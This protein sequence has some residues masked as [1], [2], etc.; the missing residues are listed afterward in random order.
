[1]TFLMV[2]EFAR[3]PTLSAALFAV[4]IAATLSSTVGF[5]FSA[6]AAGILLQMMNDQVAVVEIMLISSIALQMYSVALLRRDI[7]F[8]R[9]K[10]HLLGGI[11][12]MPV[13][14]YMLL[15]FNTAAYSILVGGF[16]ATY[17]FITFLR[18]MPIISW[19]GRFI[20]AVVG[21]VGGITGPL[22]AF[23]GAAIAIWCGTR[24][25]DKVTQRCVYQPYILIMQ[26]LTLAALIM[27]GEAN[28]ID[29]LHGL[30]VIPAVVGAHIGVRIFMR[31]TDAQFKA[32]VSTLLVVSGLWILGNGLH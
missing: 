2:Y 6:I 31:I 23:P 20:D 18:K 4:F 13:G 9:I 19:G 11:L 25:W 12:T 24:G 26:V 14:L 3:L 8:S 16:L 1:M 32:L 7:V 29:V 5:A 27:L 15:A 10:W 21:G 28:H 30:F 17:G 22:V